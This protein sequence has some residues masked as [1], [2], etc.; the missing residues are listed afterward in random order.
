MRIKS[1][2]TRG[3]K[4]LRFWLLSTLKAKVSSF[5]ARFDI[6]LRMH[7]C[8]HDT[9]TEASWR[10]KTIMRTYRYFTDREL[11]GLFKAHVLNYLEYRTPGVYHA[12]STVLAPLDRVL[13]NFLR[14]MSVDEVDALVVF[15]LAP[16]S[17][18][19]DIAM[20]GVIHRT[21]LGQGPPAFREYFR[22][23]TSQLRR[24]D[25]QCRHNRQV[26]A[27]FPGRN[28]E[29]FR[30]SAFGL[31]RADLQYASGIRCAKHQ[32]ARIPA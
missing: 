3:R 4:H 8:V 24:S 2:L 22:L 18:R 11:I 29:T 26:V 14:Q 28:H 19:R 21:L 31:T 13:S 6:N 1:P 25:R 9:V 17:C 32:R 10:L 30:R 15:R 5:S 16:L 12:C 27:Q 23:D 20:L 7:K